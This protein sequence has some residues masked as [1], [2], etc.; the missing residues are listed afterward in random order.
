MN[1][2][3]PSPRRSSRL[4]L[5]VAIL[6]LLLGLGFTWQSFQYRNLNAQFDHSSVHLQ[7][8]VDDVM[9]TEG[10]STSKGIKPSTLHVTYHFEAPDGRHQA[11]ASVTVDT[12]HS[13]TPGDPVPIKYLP[14][15]PRR[16]RLDL[17]QE[18]ARHRQD[19]WIELASGI[20][21]LVFAAI[22]FRKWIQG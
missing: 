18:D 10:T 6:F 16:S 20:G 15:N 8:V 17:P 9:E 2:R 21:L 5:F 11:K 4:F 19:V 7:G 14:D 13:L 22:F 3:N 12:F 1:Q